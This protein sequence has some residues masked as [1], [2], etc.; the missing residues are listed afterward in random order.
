[1]FSTLGPKLR[2]SKALQDHGDKLLQI[3]IKLID[4]IYSHN[5]C[6][7]NNI[8]M[9]SCLRE[10]PQCC[11]LLKLQPS[12]SLQSQVIRDQLQVW[13]SFLF[14]PGPA[15]SRLAQ[16]ARAT[17][18]QDNSL[19]AA[20]DSGDPAVCKYLVE[21]TPSYPRTVQ[22]GQRIKP[23]R[24]FFQLILPLNQLLKTSYLV[25]FSVLS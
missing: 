25:S 3:R 23:D 20:E 24:Y 12:V 8:R 21:A 6:V 2:G 7:M 17:G 11:F 18:A 1:M 5:N 19:G 4:Y 22:R 10:N 16:H 14:S 13:F 15:S 9:I